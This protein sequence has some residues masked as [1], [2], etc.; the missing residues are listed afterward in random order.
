MSLE[1]ACSGSAMRRSG[2]KLRRIQDDG[3]KAL[4]FLRNWRSEAFTSASRKVARFG[5]NPLSATW[6]RGAL[7]GR[8]G[9]IDGGHVPIGHIAARMPASAATEAAGVAKAVEHT[10]E[11]QALGVVG[12]P[13]AAV[14]LVQIKAGLVASAMLRSAPLVLADRQFQRRPSPS[15]AAPVEGRAASRWRAQTFQRTHAGVR[16]LVQLA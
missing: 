11:A 3:V 7:Q 1:G 4:A 9:G 16:A 15:P 13:L 6:A 12:K 10:L 2:R 14:A 8:A 5:S